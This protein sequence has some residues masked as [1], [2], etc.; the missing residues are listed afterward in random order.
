MAL[1]PIDDMLPSDDPLAPPP[2]DPLIAVAQNPRDPSEQILERDKPE[3]D[4]KRKALV[5]ALTDMVKQGKNHWDKVFRQMEKD[6]KFAAGA[7][8][9]ED[10]KIS[11]FNDLA[12]NDLYVANITLQHIQKR[13]AAIYAKNPQAVCRRRPRMLSTVWDGTMES[14]TQAQGVVQQAQQ[15]SMMAMMAGRPGHGGLARRRRPTAWAECRCPAELPPGCRCQAPPAPTQWLAP[16]EEPLP[17][18]AVGRRAL[19]AR[20][21]RLAP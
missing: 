10:P 19:Q 7:Q 16:R 3:P 4:P 14:L 2:V 11:V 12:D 20:R 17:V 9:P 21:G 1:P 13:V 8:W 18:A 6:Q 5:G 15:V